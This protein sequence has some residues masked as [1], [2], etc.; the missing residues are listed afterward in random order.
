MNEELSV[1]IARVQR[2][3]D[4][5]MRNERL[6]RLYATFHKRIALEQATMTTSHI[7]GPKTDYDK[8]LHA[9][10]TCADALNKARENEEVAESFVEM[11]RV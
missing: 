1:E 5:P 3:R 11:Q 6:H 10:I 8:A 9:I 4:T 2:M 7:L